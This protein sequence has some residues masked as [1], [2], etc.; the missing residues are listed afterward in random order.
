M[1]PVQALIT[2][3]GD[4]FNFRAEPQRALLVQSE[5]MRRATTMSRA[6]HVPCAPVNHDLR[7]SG[8]RRFF[9]PL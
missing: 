7:L 1:E 9:L 3:V 8:E 6:N 5:I 4:Q 2:A